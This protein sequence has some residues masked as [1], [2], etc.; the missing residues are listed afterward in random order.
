MEFLDGSTWQQIS[1]WNPTAAD[2]GWYIDDVRV[3][4][5]LTSAATVSVDTADRSG[6]PACGPV[7]TGVTASLVATPAIARCDEPFMVDA[8]GSTADQCPGGVLQF[9]FWSRWAEQSPGEAVNVG[10][11][12]MLQ[13]W[14]E[15][16]GTSAMISDVPWFGPKLY[17]V[18]VRC[19]TLP[20]C[21]ASTTVT[22]PLHAEP[23]PFP[24]MLYSGVTVLFWHT[25][26]VVDVVRG[27]L[28]TLRASGG[29]FEGSV[30]TCLASRYNA[31]A[32]SDPSIPP[33]GENWYYLIRE[34]NRYPGCTFHSWTTGSP[35]EVPGGGGTRDEDIALDMDHCPDPREE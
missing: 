35:A 31:N 11:A 33:P 24:Y 17:G 3:S 23:V 15:N 21:G 14:S 19:S 6:L 12:D 22:V 28:G 30:E 5:T 29:N 4:N 13:D 2:D 20:A 26:T 34:S 32:L 16:G 1:G 25:T 9:R 7:C 10:N 27:D 18:D 8:S